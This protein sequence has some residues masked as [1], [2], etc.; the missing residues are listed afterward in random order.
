MVLDEE[1]FVVFIAAERRGYKLGVTLSSEGPEGELLV[2]DSEVEEEFV[3]FE[4]EANAGKII[5]GVLAEGG[6]FSFFVVVGLE[7]GVFEDD[8]DVD[9]SGVGNELQFQLIQRRNEVEELHSLQ[10]LRPQVLEN[11]LY[12]LSFQLPPQRHLLVFLQHH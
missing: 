2:G 7:K 12:Y 10:V 1:I 9:V 11:L 8:G 3:V 6:F 4:D 5:E